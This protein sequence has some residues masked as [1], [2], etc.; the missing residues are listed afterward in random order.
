MIKIYSTPTCENCTKAKA[1][2]KMMNVQF[3]ELDVMDDFEARDEMMKKSGKLTVPVIDMNGKI[4]IGFDRM[5]IDEA[6]EEM[7]IL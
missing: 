1:Y 5:A 3:E 6:L 2:L 7:D 4:I